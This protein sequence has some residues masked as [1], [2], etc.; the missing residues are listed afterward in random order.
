L[1]AARRSAKLMIWLKATSFQPNFSRSSKGIFTTRIPSPAARFAK[2]SGERLGA[3]LISKTER[4]PLPRKS[5]PRGCG[6]AQCTL[7][8]FPENRARRRHRI[9]SRQSFRKSSAAIAIFGKA[10][11][12]ALSNVINGTP[13]CQRI[14][15]HWHRPGDAAKATAV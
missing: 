13:S 1:K 14:P 5:L 8:R 3:C 4:F 15:P 6:L 9:Y 7:K 12:M 11:L 2:G 10:F